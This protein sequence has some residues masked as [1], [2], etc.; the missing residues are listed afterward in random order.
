MRVLIDILHPAHV[1][2]FR[3]FYAEMTARGHELHITARAKDRSL[4]LL[5]RYELPYE[6]ISDQR[7]GAVGMTT[8][9]AQRTRK[10]MQIMRDFRPDVM[11]G[12]MGP[13]I[14]LAGAL[15]RV[16]AVVFYDTEFARQTNWF[17]YPLA[18]SVCTPDCYQ[19]KVRGTHVEYAG[20][21]ELAYLHPNRFMP[22]A[23]RLA[24]FG[25]APD[26]PYSLVRFVSWQAVHD[27]N[28]KGLT[29]D[30][31][32]AL[33]ETLQRHGRVLISSEAPLPADLAPLEVKGPVQDIHHLLAFAQLVVGESATMSSESAVLGVPA[34]MIATTG[35]GYTDDEERRYG[36][37]RHFTEDQYETA[38]ATI[39]KLYA[40]S[41][42][43]MGQLARRRLLDEKID[44][45]QWMVDYFENTFSRGS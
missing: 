32:R 13:S 4:D 25:V 28:E 6:H 31:K 16:P 7:S 33:V 36:L 37:V 42:R 24:A 35:R 22:D 10:L 23:S 3:N 34:V 21:H 43:E 38:V 17:V 11:T 39:E 18:H 45:T 2:F 5:D 26:E 15:K 44:V 29:G 9:M 19:G 27:R 41:P 1:H 8:E 20:Y 14:A 12:I 30:Q 40:E